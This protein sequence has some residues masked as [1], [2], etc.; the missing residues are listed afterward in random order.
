M[1]ILQ[2]ASEVLGD[3]DEVIECGD[4]APHGLKV[5]WPAA[6]VLAGV[7]VL[8]SGRRRRTSCADPWA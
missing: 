3:R 6:L 4:G 7:F 2:V 8:T 1:G 5:R